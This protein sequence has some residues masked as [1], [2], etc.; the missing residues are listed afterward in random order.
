[1]R[2]EQI[3]C[4]VNLKPTTLLTFNCIPHR[5]NSNNWLKMHRKPMRRKPLKKPSANLLLMGNMGHGQSFTDRMKLL[6]GEEYKSL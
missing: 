3:F 2:E 4:G 1:M 6:H 5:E